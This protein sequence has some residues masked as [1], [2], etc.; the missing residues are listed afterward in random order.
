MPFLAQNWEGLEA[1]KTVA[2]RIPVASRD[3]FSLKGTRASWRNGCLQAPGTGKVQGGT[4]TEQ[5][6]NQRHGG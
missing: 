4:A 5:G 2:L 3:H 6:N 1:M